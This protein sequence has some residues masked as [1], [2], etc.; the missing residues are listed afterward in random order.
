VK[1]GIFG[2]TG[3]VGQ[4]LVARALETGHEVTAL[5]R[6]PSKLNL[7][8]PKLHVV[9]GDATNAKDVDAIVQA[10]DAILNALGP[11]KTS[12]KNILE[13][14][15]GLTVSAMKRFGVKRLIVVG[16]A[17][18][19][20]PQDS[21]DFGTQAIGWLIS[22]II[23]DAVKDK[24]KQY[25]LLKQ[26]GLEFVILRAPQIKDG[27]KVGRYTIGYP[28]MGFGAQITPADLSDAMLEMLTGDKFLGTAPAIRS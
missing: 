27:P 25:D 13:I 9:K 8:H 1:L 4:A 22:K 2:A 5:A 17:G 10:Q 28:P 23:A 15:T 12:P 19:R 24:Q 14:S 7:T 26:S 11:T 6:D 3:K 21:Q 18:M 20:V 16:G